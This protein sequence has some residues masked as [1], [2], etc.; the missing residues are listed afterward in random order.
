MIWSLIKIL[1]FVGFTALLAYTAG[2]LLETDGHLRIVALGYEFTFGPFQ[3]VILVIGL[4]LAI[5]VILRLS[6]LLFATLRFVNGDETAISRYFDRNRERRGFEALAD[7]MMALASGEGK[8]AMAKAARA[9]KYLARPELTNLLAAQAAEL[10]GDRTKAEEVYKRLLQDDRT[11]FVGVRGIMK[12]KL[13][14][15]D[16]DTALTLAERA[17][18][19]KPRH[20]ETSDILLRLQ[21]EK[22]DWSGARR[23]LGAKLRSGALP[24]DVHRRRDAVLALSEGTNGSEDLQN[25]L[26]LEANRLSPDLVPAAV[27]AARAYIAQGKPRPATKTIKK[28]WTTHPHPELAAV[29]AEIVPDET[30]TDRQTRFQQLLRINPDHEENRLV[31]TELAIAAEDF[32]GAREAL[33]DLAQTHP[34]TRTLAL[35]AAIER[36]VGADEQVVRAHL[37]R[38]VNA[39]RGPAW[40]CDNCNSVEAAWGPI[41]G[42]CGGLDTLRWREPVVATEA[43][44]EEE[45]LSIPAQPEDIVDVVE[46]DDLAETDAALD[47]ETEVSEE[48]RPE[49]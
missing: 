29:F 6:G 5:W 44:V 15:G 37:T 22:N 21:A 19:L 48:N 47:V 42:N 30:P 1:A 4:I 33:G 43:P 34:T 14:E 16:T 41:C 17:F 12:Q 8:L 7:G 39:A 3:A 13:A 40:V 28:A 36:G 38:A 45:F 49:S 31:Q 32:V 26:A 25:E 18:A 24:R 9:E 2:L 27:G 23:T 10:A 35:L 11:R 46:L 20:D